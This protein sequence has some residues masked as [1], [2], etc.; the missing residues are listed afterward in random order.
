MRDKKQKDQDSLFLRPMMVG[1]AFLFTAQFLFQIFFFFFFVQQKDGLISA[2]FLLWQ[3][4]QTWPV[5][6]ATLFS[7]LVYFVLLTFIS[8]SAL[9]AS[10]LLVLRLKIKETVE[11]VTILNL[12]LIYLALMVINVYRFPQTLVRLTVIDSWSK[13]GDL[14]PY[15]IAVIFLAVIFAACCAEI[16]IMFKRVGKDRF[17]PNRWLVTALIMV[18]VLVPAFLHNQSGTTPAYVS[19]R[20]RTPQQ[21]NIILIGL[22]SLRVDVIEDEKLRQKYLPNLNVYLDEEQTAWFTNTFTPIARTFSAWYALLSGVEPKKSGVRYNLQY[23]SESQKT[24]TI[25]PTLAEQGY[26]TVYGSDEKRFSAVD[27][28]YGFENTFGPPPG[29]ADWL[30]S[31]IEDNPI[32]NL[33]RG[34]ALAATLL[35]HTHANRAAATVYY[36]EYFVDEV[37]RELSTYNASKPLF[38]SIHLCLSHWPFTWA[39]GEVGESSTNIGVYFNALKEL[40]E[41]FGNIM[42]VLNQSG[43]LKDSIIVVLS[44]HGEGLVSKHLN[45]DDSL[46]V[47]FNELL[48]AAKDFSTGHG[49][50]LLTV[51]QNKVLLSVRDYAGVSGIEPGRHD[52]LASLLDIAPTIARV[53]GINNYRTDGIDLSAVARGLAGDRLVFME[54]GFDLAALHRSE[55]DVSLL[56]EQGAST[57]EIDETGLMQVK[58]DYHDHIINNKQFGVTDGRFLVANSI[59]LTTVGRNQSELV[60]IDIQAQ[61]GLDEAARSEDDRVAELKKALLSYYGDE[62][63]KLASKDDER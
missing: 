28:T 44:D 21:P 62:L 63:Q 59:D 6:K 17:R 2:R 37:A 34:T 12:L 18:F 9:F 50:D 26:L 46:L 45:E 49:T 14:L 61:N 13:A 36:P 43:A 20:E 4:I 52:E 54:T 33:L 47:Q 60:A 24:S 53:A 27:G 39:S 10:R 41:Q 58:R 38:L 11:K 30:L 25:V 42:T 51:S 23:L 57:Y 7:V 48:P 1:V 16:F 8:A 3:G 40:D 5:L 15:L 29:A 31:F 22:D 35:P 55:L 32:H 56:V 19:E